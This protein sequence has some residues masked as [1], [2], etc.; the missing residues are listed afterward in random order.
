MDT[1]LQAH[2]IATAA[3]GLDLGLVSVIMP[4]YNGA[5]YIKE[6]IE[7][8]LAQTYQNWE[9]I[10]VDDCSTDNSVEIIESFDDK[11]IRLLHNEENSGAAISRNRAIDA[12]N[13][14]WIAFLDSDDLWIEDK[15]HSHIQFMLEMDTPLSFTDYIVIDSDEAVIKEFV[16]N[17]KVYD[18]KTI[19]KHCYIGCSTAIYDAEKLGK[20]YMPPEADKREDFA[21]WLSILRD[22]KT[23][24]CF[25]RSLT[26]YRIH[27]KSVSSNKLQM[28][29]YQWKVYRKIEKL[30]FVKSMYYMMHWAIK[31]VLKYR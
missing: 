1:N 4:N 22:G 25:H 30:S 23:A 31:G 16:P 27:T 14:R 13:G 24:E 11:R 12:A 18:Y 21:C 17:Q 29:K 19:L 5:K 2:G 7:S 26:T 15:L 10:I 28:I 9:L 8:V 6:T 20:V 3:V